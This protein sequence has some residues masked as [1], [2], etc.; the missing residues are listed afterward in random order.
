M[1]ALLLCILP[2]GAY[3][4]HEVCIQTTFLAKILSEM[5]VFFTPNTKI[6]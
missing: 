2:C 6:Y 1:G 5:F 3:H 4:M